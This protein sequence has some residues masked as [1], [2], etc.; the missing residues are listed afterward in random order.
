MTNLA[1]MKVQKTNHV[2]F[3]G[4]CYNANG[5]RYEIFHDI[6]GA[7]VVHK[8]VNNKHVDVFEI[9]EAEKVLRHAGV[10]FKGV[11]HD[12]L[13]GRVVRARVNF[14]PQH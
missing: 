7:H 2:T 1:E 9:D 8:F 12:L 3:V 14:Q 4:G 5:T 6:T 10:S 11:F 13:G